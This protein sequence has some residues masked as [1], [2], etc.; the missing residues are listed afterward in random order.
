[1]INTNFSI[2]HVIFL[3]VR[4]GAM[5]DHSSAAAT[6]SSSFFFPFVPSLMFASVSL[7]VMHTMLTQQHVT[8]STR[9]VRPT[10]PQDLKAL[11]SM[12]YQ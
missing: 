4:M 7:F 8:L 3:M 12:Q 11:T 1:M 10:I 5:D 9:P 2:V 6:N